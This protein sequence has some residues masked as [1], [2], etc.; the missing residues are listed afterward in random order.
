MTVV[1]KIKLFWALCGLL[2]TLS[3]YHETRLRSTTGRGLEPRE[4]RYDPR[5]GDFARIVALSPAL[6]RSDA[7]R[8]LWCAYAGRDSGL[9]A[10]RFRP[11]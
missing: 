1:P 9:L 5:R 8:A 2:S 6:S 4:R 7:L 3:V 11:C 10:G